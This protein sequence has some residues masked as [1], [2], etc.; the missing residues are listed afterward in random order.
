[1]TIKEP[2]N[3]SSTSGGFRPGPGAQN[4]YFCFSPFQFRG[5]PRFFAKITHIS[6][7]FAFPNFRKVSKFAASIER[8]KTK[9]AS[10]S[11]GFPSPRALPWTPL[12][13][14]L[15]EPRYRLA[16]PRSPWGRAPRYCGLEPPLSSTYFS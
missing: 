8:P 15:P 7:F 2:V 5:H 1:M 9:S 3:A 12:G 4:P 6:D 10:A 13:A 11:G 16:L 14:L